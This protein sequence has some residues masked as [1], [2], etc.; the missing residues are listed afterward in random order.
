LAAG[1]AP[2][3]L[4]GGGANASVPPKKVH[5]IEVHARYVTGVIRMLF[6]LF[7]LCL[8]VTTKRYDTIS[9]VQADRYEHMLYNV[10]S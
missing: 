2:I 8:T 9:R 1:N 6:L 4:G 5:R 3:C 7:L 10:V